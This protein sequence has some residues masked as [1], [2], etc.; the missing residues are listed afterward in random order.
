[1]DRVDWTDGSHRP[2]RV[3]R[4][5]AHLETR[6]MQWRQELKATSALGEYGAAA[7]ARELETEGRHAP[8]L[9]TI[10]RVLARRGAFDDGSVYVGPRHRRAGIC[11]VSPR[12]WRNSTAGI[13]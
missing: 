1:L 3:R 6:I 10:N 2:H 12:A 11:R 13:S 9:R 5:A 7:I 8:S 4:I